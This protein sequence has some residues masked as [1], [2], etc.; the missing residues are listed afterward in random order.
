MDQAHLLTC[1]LPLDSTTKVVRFH[2]PRI[3]ELMKQR[4][5][6]LEKLAIEAN[7]AF[8]E[9]VRRFIRNYIPL[10]NVV[11]SMATLDAIRSLARLGTLPGWTRPAIVEVEDIDGEAPSGAGLL[12]LTSFRHP[13]SEALLNTSSTGYVPNDLTIGG[14]TGVKGILL[15]GSNMGGKSSLVRAVALCVILAQLGACVPADEARLTVHDAVLTRMGASDDLAR[16]RSTFRVEVEETAE[17]LRTATGRSLVILD[18]LGRGT[19]TN[20]GTAVAYAVL[21][22]LMTRPLPRCPSLLFITHYFTLGSVA[23]DP[24]LDG[25]LRNMHMAYSEAVDEETQR[26]QVVFLHKLREGLASSS[27]G[28]HCAELA[29]LPKALTERAAEEAGA[30]QRQTEQ[31]RAEKRRRLLADVVR[32]VFGAPQLEGDEKAEDGGPAEAALAVLNR[33]SEA[34]Q[35]AL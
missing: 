8:D 7:E 15:T 27:F 9:F 2:T 29:G 6:L 35:T 28:I 21:H 34:A 11:T 20:D 19:S 10:R 12:S 1:S 3:I 22:H 5:Q 23:A 17:I 30:L 25:R 13:M 33:V 26:K 32:G 31:K 18:E 24:K 4:D 16:N 14:E